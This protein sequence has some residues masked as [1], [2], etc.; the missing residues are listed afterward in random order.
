M[1]SRT[2]N[3]F[4]IWSKS[5]VSPDAPCLCNFVRPDAERPA[6]FLW[7]K[8]FNGLHKYAVASWKYEIFQ[9]DNG[10]IW[11][12]NIFSLHLAIQFPPI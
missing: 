8:H 1:H 7:Y 5:E 10:Q 6:H 3:I 2:Q 12:W 4:W 9:F 11:S